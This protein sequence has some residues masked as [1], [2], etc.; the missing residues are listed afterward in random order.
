MYLLS[1]IIPTSGRHQTLLKVLDDINTKIGKRKDVEVIVED[2]GKNSISLDNTIKYFH[3]PL[4]IS[5]TENFDRA[6]HKTSGDFVLILGDDDFIGP[7]FNKFL[8]NINKDISAYRFKKAFYY[9]NGHKMPFSW[10]KKSE[11]LRFQKYSG[12][13]SFINSQEE[14]IKVANSGGVNMFNLPSVYHGLVKRTVLMSLFSKYDTC[15]P[16]PSPDMANGVAV[17]N[18]IDYFM[19]ID[20]PLIISGKG[21]RSKGD[22]MVEHSANLNNVKHINKKYIGSWS[23]NILKYWLAETV[24]AESFLQAQKTFPNK[25]DLNFNALNITLLINHKKTLN[26]LGYNRRK[27]NISRS[28]YFIEFLKNKLFKLKKFLNFKKVILNGGIEDV[29]N[30]LITSSSKNIN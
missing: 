4:K 9:F 16:G 25:I 21:N 11:W 18:E 24:W 6:I 13:K 7:G 23:N 22:I 27:L 20:L 28:V 17:A 19:F 14:L 29:N 10:Q 2:N 15:F 5:I 8:D 12:A 1:I 30:I 3:N 26:I